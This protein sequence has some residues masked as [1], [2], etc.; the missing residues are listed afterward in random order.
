MRSVNRNYEVAVIGGGPAGSAAA[1]TLAR[2]GRRVLLIDKNDGETFKIGES[3]PPI[4]ARLLDELGVLERLHTDRHMISYGNQSAWGNSALVSTDFIRD[5]NGPGWHVDRTSF[6]AMLRDAARYAG[7]DVLEETRASHV[8]RRG[9]TDWRLDLDRIDGKR[10]VCSKWLLDC[11]GRR[12]WL[13]HREGVRRHNYDRLVAFVALFRAAGSGRAPD[14]DTLTLIESVRDGW[15][16]TAR[17]PDGRRVV[18]YLTDTGTDTAARA[19]SGEGFY[20][21]VDETIHIRARL[22][23]G[24]YAMTGR[25]SVTSANSAR[26]ERVTGEGW[27]A[28]GDAGASFDPLSSQGILTAL[29]SGLKAGQAIGSHLSGN[30]RALRD[31]AARIDS[32]YDAYVSNRSLFYAYESRWPETRF[33]RQR[34]GDFRPALLSTETID[35]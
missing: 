19:R 30:Q 5:P 31:Y 24:G 14:R 32:V 22:E 26:L 27:L 4:A 15:W 17:V 1:I 28:A 2:A 12:S 34:L 10:E 6:D 25:P 3:L 33:W 21:L 11:S 20:A 18:V 35:V 16:Y 8:E 29:Y 9:R 13:A 7:A 23:A